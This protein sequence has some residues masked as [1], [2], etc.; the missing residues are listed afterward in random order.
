LKKVLRDKAE[1]VSAEG[2]TAREEKD[3]ESEK[4][5]KRES[6]HEEDTGRMS[7]EALKEFKKKMGID[8]LSD[9]MHPSKLSALERRAAAK[10][11][12]GDPGKRRERQ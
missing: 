4:V 9:L 10:R 11:G 12:N 7:P 5:R 6:E 2:L 8:K 3:R 1:R